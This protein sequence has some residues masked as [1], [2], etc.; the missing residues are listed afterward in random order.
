MKKLWR[1][2][3]RFPKAATTSPGC[4]SCRAGTTNPCGFWKVF[5]RRSRTLS[6]FCR[7]CSEGNL[8]ALY[9][10]SL[11]REARGERRA[12]YD[13]LSTA[14]LLGPDDPDVLRRLGVLET[15]YGSR[16][17]AIQYLK[18][19]REKQADDTKTGFFLVRL[20]EEEKLYSEALLVLENLLQKKADD[21]GMRFE[22]AYLLLAKAEEKEAGLE[23][24]AKAA[25]LGF[26]DKERAA[27]LLLD[28]PP[29]FLQEVRKTVVDSGLLSAEEAEQA[30]SAPFVDP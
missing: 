16:T 26:E 7:P 8:S 21:P 28:V 14:R 12:A 10:L 4:T 23:A 25:G 13:L 11:L 15:E 24:L 22:Q 5:G 29:A 20:L 17:A 27:A 3:R 1:T 18:S 30:L 9:N 19:Y 6:S 2:A